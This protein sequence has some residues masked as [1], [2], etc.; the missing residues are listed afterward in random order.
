MVRGAGQRAARH[1]DDADRRHAATQLVEDD[2]HVAEL[3][4]SGYAD[5]GVA[6]AQGR[7]VVAELAGSQWDYRRFA[8]CGDA[9]VGRRGRQRGVVGRAIADDVDAPRPGRPQGLGCRPGGRHALCEGG[10]DG[11]A[12]GCDLDGDD[13]FDHGLAALRCDLASGRR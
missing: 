1:V 6:L 3:A 9:A 11:L 13:A 12:F 4:G 5:H 2:Y 8:G 10:P 7:S